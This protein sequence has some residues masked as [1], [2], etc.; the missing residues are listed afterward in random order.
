MSE[1]TVRLLLR[2][3]IGLKTKLAELAETEHRSLNKQIEFMLEQSMKEKTSGE[4]TRSA[5]SKG[6]E[7]K[8]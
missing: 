1:Q 6:E 2:I 7:R 4:A 5:R 8:R 3:P